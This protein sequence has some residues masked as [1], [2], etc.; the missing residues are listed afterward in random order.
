MSSMNVPVSVPVGELSCRR[1]P[2]VGLA[3]RLTNVPPASSP[4]IVKKQRPLKT[5]RS[6]LA[7]E[8]VCAGSARCSSLSVALRVYFMPAKPMLS[9]HSWR[10]ATCPRNPL[11]L[12]GGVEL[13][14]ASTSRVPDPKIEPSSVPGVLGIE[15]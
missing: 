9:C 2:C 15:M 6:M 13:S 10:F 8:P 7:T 11:T 4:D 14:T 1:V 3:I 12:A 5:S